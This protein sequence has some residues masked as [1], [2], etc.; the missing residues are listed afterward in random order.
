VSVLL[1]RRVSR[2]RASNFSPNQVA[3]LAGWYKADA[4]VGVTSGTGIGS[5]PDSS[6]NG[7][8]GTQGNSGARPAYQTNIVNGLPVARFDGG[9]DLI[10]SGVS[11]SPVESTT[12][13]VLR[14]TTTSGGLTIRGGFNGANTGGLQYRINSGKQLLVKQF[15]AQIGSPGTATLSTSVFSVVATALTTGASATY[16]FYLNGAPDG[17]GSHT[18]TFS[19]GQTTLIGM[20]Q[21]GTNEPFSGDLAELICYSAVLSST[22]RNAVTAYLGAKYGITVV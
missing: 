1:R 22:D 3:G 5:W 16:A 11:A 2:R 14:P 4:I 10:E 21:G 15:V 13:A 18:Q 7:L 12:F 6:S 19:T 9:N 20:G 17:N 8:T